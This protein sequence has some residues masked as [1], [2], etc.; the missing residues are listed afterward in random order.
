MEAF[1]HSAELA[2]ELE[3]RWVPHEFYAYEDLSRYFSTSSDN[4]TTQQMFQDAPIC[5]CGSLTPE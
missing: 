5:L 4:A 3:C 2:E 1:S